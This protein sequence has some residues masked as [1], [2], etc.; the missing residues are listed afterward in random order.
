MN[1]MPRCSVWLIIHTCLHL[2]IEMNEWTPTSHTLSIRMFVYPCV[3]HVDHSSAVS[4]VYLVTIDVSTQSFAYTNHLTLR[5]PL[6][7]ILDSPYILSYH[8]LS[9]LPLMFYSRV[10][11]FLFVS[12]YYTTQ[13]NVYINFDLSCT[14]SHSLT[15][16]TQVNSQLHTIFFVIFFLN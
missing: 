8:F 9:L 4:L 16:I 15:H 3:F 2:I 11:L 12:S 6:S 5:S 10:F 1:S 14:I 7:L 13:T